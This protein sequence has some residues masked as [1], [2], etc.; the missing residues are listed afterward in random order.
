MENF[1]A[2][3]DWYRSGTGVQ[4][5][6]SDLADFIRHL[7]PGVE[8]LGVEGGCCVTCNTPGKSAPFVDRIDDGIFVA[9]GGCGERR[10][11]FS[12]F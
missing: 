9:V 2:L 11:L 10:I 4:E 3:R 8:I 5:A 12:V 6:V 1:K 7:I